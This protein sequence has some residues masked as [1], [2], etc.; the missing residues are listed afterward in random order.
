MQDFSD[1]LARCLDEIDEN[2]YSID[3]VVEAYPADSDELKSL[4][5]VAGRIRKARNND[6]ISAEVRTRSRRSFF[7]RLK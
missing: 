2:N 3:D 1:V 5:H 6:D 7:R 4:L